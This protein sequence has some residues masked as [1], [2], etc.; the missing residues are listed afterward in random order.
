MAKIK[1]YRGL[2]SLYNQETHADGLYFAT[3]THKI[4]LNNQKYGGEDLG[5]DKVVSNVELDTDPNKLK[6]SFNDGSSTT[7]DLPKPD[8]NYTSSI[9]NKDLTMPNAVG[10]FAKGTKV[11][12]LEGK[13]QNSMW[14]DLL[15][16]TVNPTFT[17][18]SAS[19]SL[20]GYQSVV[21][22]GVAGPNLTTNFTT[23]YNPGAIMLNG[24]KQANRGGALKAGE[25]F[26]YV[27][28]SE[29]NRTTPEKIKLGDTTF[30]YKAAYEAGP[31][32]KDN[33]GNNYSTPLGAGTVVSGAVKVN[34]TYPWYATTQNGQLT[35]Q[36]LVAWNNSAG[37]MQTPEFTVVAHNGANVKQTF[38]VPRKATELQ[39][40]NSVS[41]KWEVISGFP[42]AGGWAE[43]HAEE[44]VNGTMVDYYTYTY[45]GEARASQKLKV[46]F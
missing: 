31:Q 38:K 10:G 45:S 7:V 36:A 46:K 39:M 19:L 21:E 34:G 42:T 25:S 6:V 15:F 23:G 44:D 4:I 43:T 2:E 35:K 12:D 37:S 26:I 9:E 27:D 32:P 24:Q 40:Y 13:S 5:V 3:D 14:D 33:K 11:S 16:P 17:A 29:A 8:L 22:A 20:K 1:F 41:G 28:G 30:N 18:P